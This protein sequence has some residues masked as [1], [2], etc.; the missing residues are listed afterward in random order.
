[1]FKA[2]GGLLRCA[3]LPLLKKRQV[4]TPAIGLSS[5]SRSQRPVSSSGSMCRQYANQ[6]CLAQQVPLPV[7]PRPR[8]QP[9]PE[10]LQIIGQAAPERG[11]ME[12]VAMPRRS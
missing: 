6:K 5:Y 3:F 9:R 2:K 4:D 1:M 12:H 7:H 8:L 10:N 11:L